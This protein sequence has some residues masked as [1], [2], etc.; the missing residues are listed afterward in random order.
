MTIYYSLITKGFYDTETVDYPSLPN[1]VIEITK[2]QHI[3]F[4]HLI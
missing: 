3:S 2:E 1:D 4:I